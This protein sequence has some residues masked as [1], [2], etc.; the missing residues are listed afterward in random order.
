M[1]DT[2]TPNYGWVL[3]EIGG[4]AAVW[5]ASLNN[6]FNLIDA[7]VFANQQAD[8]P[9]GSGALWFTATPPTNWL[10][11]NGASLST[12]AYATLFA[13]IGYTYG[14]SGVNFNLPNL[15][16]VFPYGAG[17]VALGATG[18]AASATLGLGNLPSHAHTIT[19]VAHSHGLTQSGHV[20]PDPGHA[21]SA[22]GSQD[23]HN[24]TV[25]GSFGFG[26]GGTA[27]PSPLMSEGSTTTSTAQPN[28]YVN[29]A[30]AGANLQAADANISVNASGTGLS[31]TNAAGS[32]TPTPVPTVPPFLG[33]NFIIRF[34]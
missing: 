14:G 33:I 29:V 34:Q 32:A 6:N 28:V 21:H 17:G 24:H 10:I 2:L 31:A 16:N 8:S 12:T 22:S 27:P 20:H 18:G 1:A 30:A 5:G 7:Q 15:Q 25:G 26:V 9:I 23:P 4:D 3:P 19:D 11:C 13:V